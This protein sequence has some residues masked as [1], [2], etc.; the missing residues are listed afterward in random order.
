LVDD[1]NYT[2]YPL[3]KSERASNDKVVVSHNCITSQAPGTALEFALVLV[4]RLVDQKKAATI[5]KET[6]FSW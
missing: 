5:A 1:E 4:E 6:V 2:G 3:M